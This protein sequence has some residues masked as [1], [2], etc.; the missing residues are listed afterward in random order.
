MYCGGYKEYR[1][2]KYWLNYREL[3]LL[4]AVFRFL[5]KAYVE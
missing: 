4:G 3:A 1:G 2:E 5:A